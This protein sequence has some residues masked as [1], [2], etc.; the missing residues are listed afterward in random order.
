MSKQEI[1]VKINECLTKRHRLNKQIEAIDN[2]VK[3]LLDEYHKA[4][5]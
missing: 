2:K 3:A 4:A 5:D 1:V